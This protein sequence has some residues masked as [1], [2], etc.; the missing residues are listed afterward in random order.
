[1]ADE[2]TSTWEA[3]S[4]DSEQAIAEEK[5][6][7][8]K[9][10][11]IR[12]GT[13]HS[14]GLYA[15]L[16]DLGKYHILEAR[17]DI[18]AFLTSEDSEERRAALRT[19]TVDFQLQEHW[20]TARRFLENDPDDLC[21]ITAASAFAALMADTHDSSTLRLLANMVHNEEEDETVRTAAYRA[22]LSV[23]G[24]P[25]A[26]QFATSFSSRFNFPQD[27]KWELVDQYLE[28]KNQ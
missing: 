24:R 4:E 27:V 13:L 17:P 22:I 11:A 3:N 14:P 18:E 10:A 6:L 1:M 28:T 25:K 15:V 12:K 2:E 9:L 7:R 20:E 16:V 26:E 21:R 8:E 19:L 5:L 23:L